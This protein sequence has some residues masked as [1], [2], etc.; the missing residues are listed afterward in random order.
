MSTVRHMLIGAAMACLPLSPVSAAE[1]VNLY[2][3]REPGLIQPMLDLFTK[4]TGVKVNAIFVKDGLLERV[5]A[6]GENSP[7]DVL[8]TVDFGKLK[9]LVDGGVTQEVTA[10]ALQKAIPASLRDPDHHWFALTM[11]ARVIYVSKDRVKDEQL[12]YEDLADPKWKG[13]ICIRSGQHPYNTALIAAM[14]AK[15]GKEKTKTWLEG[16]KANLAQKPSGADRDVAKDILAGTCDIGV[17]NSYY[18]GLM[19]N[20]DLPEQR[21]WGNAIRVILPTFD[22]HKGSHVNVSGAAV[23]KHAPHAENAVRLLEFMVSPE[24]QE[25]YGKINY[26]YPVVTGVPLDKTVESLGTLKIDT[27]SLDQVAD[28]R[29]EASLLVDEVGFD[30]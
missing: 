14:I 15:H 21:A 30:N 17:G 20:S 6:E 7:A 16:V 5:K 3:T 28:H 22:D 26:E 8:I 11:R 1:E 25:T 10:P 2:T 27:L 13:K 12:T 29:K 4:E 24:A 9:D 19:R 23:A 18:V